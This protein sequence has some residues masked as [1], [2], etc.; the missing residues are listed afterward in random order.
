MIVASMAL[1]YVARLSTAP[2]VDA[3]R[4]LL[5]HLCCCCS[6]TC[7]LPN[8]RCKEMLAIWPL[9]ASLVS[10]VMLSCRSRQGS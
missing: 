7:E 8:E 1:M 2:L 10:L 9:A 5:Y 4:L 6:R 3:E